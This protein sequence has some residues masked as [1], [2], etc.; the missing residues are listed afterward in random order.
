MRCWSAPSSRIGSV[1]MAPDDRMNVSHGGRI[2][3]TRPTMILSERMNSWAGILALAFVFSCTPSD[4]GGPDD[5]V[6]DGGSPDTLEGAVDG[7]SDVASDWSAQVDASP[8]SDAVG[9]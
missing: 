8:L 2:Q 6:T 9:S 4:D 1:R 5:T 7:P 3:K